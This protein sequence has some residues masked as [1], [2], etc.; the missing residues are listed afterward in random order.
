MT[1]LFSRVPAV[2]WQD[3]FPV[4]C[5]SAGALVFGNVRHDTVLC[6]HELWYYKNLGRE[7]FGYAHLLPECRRLM[8]EGRYREAD[9]LFSDYA[10]KNN[11]SGGSCA[12]F[13]PGLNLRI[14]MDTEYSYKRYSRVLNMS[15][16]EVS[17]KYCVGD[18][19]IERKTTALIDKKIIAVKI[20]SQKNTNIGF[21]LEPHE[22]F[23]VAGFSGEPFEHGLTFRYD[24][25]GNYFFLSGKRNDT[26][27]GFRDKSGNLVTETD[28]KEPF[29]GLVLKVVP[30]YGKIQTS[31]KD[32]ATMAR[33]PHGSNISVTDKKM[34]FSMEEKRLE[35]FLCPYHGENEKKCLRDAVKVLEGLNS[36]DEES[37]YTKKYFA[38]ILE[39]VSLNVYKGEGHANEELLYDAYTDIFSPELLQKMYYYGKYLLICSS[40]ACKLPANLQGVFNGDYFPPW[41]STF[42]FNENLQM[43]YWQALTSGMPELML[44][45]F[46]LLDAKVPD[47]EINARLMYGCD[48]IRVPGY[49]DHFSGVEKDS[50]PHLLHWIGGAAW[51]SHIY[52]DYYL[53]TRDKQFLSDRAYP[54]MKK[55]MRFYADYM[56]KEEGKYKIY[57][58]E[59]PENNPC[60]KFEGSGKISAAINSTIDVAAVKELAKNL[61][62]VS[63]FLSVDAGERALWM[64]IAENLPEYQINE[65]G[66][67]KEW[68]HCDFKD[69]Y[70]HRHLSHLYPLFPGF[71]ITDIDEKLYAACKVAVEKRLIIGLNNQCGWS[72]A[73]MM[74]IYAR[75]GMGEK[76]RE[77]FEL[78]AKHCTGENLFTYH[79]DD[80]CSGVTMES[81]WSNHKPYQLDCNCGISNG[82][83]EA[84]VS[85]TPERLR[86]MHAPL[87]GLN[88][89]RLTG[90]PARCGVLADVE[91]LKRTATLRLR[92]LRDTEFA[93]CAGEKNLSV[94]L[95]KDQIK[96][97]SFTF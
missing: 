40:S 21:Y 22:I 88:R 24:S 62:T 93:L 5:G 30:Y 52:Y 96:E 27:P 94:K 10:N 75:L 69:N 20:T 3:G 48:G 56:V 64:D 38:D 55:S 49:F 18:N 85:S 80:R 33:E 9:A 31:E 77:C 81:L 71:E 90:A 73:H 74:N 91:W 29:F 13:Q 61:I 84:I 35:L 23:R 66:A 58:S 44:P 78:I 42:F 53:F 19:Q 32:M 83:V 89:G 28:S 68:L 86:V 41:R 76:V 2:K 51:L 15:K 12:L 17:V 8:D 67:M 97:I 37:S 47:F 11:I 50:Q 16:N 7:F 54:F 82:I 59:S 95:K 70:H 63:E 25:E 14:V 6:N 46:D 26:P 36:Y 60:G 87:P 57:P 1:E 4:G 79:N 34:H 92:A 65:D 39:R 45:M 43:I 72:F